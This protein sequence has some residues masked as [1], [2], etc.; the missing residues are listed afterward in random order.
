MGNTGDEKRM[1]ASVELLK[2]ML[3]EETASKILEQTG[4]L[5]SNPN[6]QITEQSGGARLNQAVECIKNAGLIIETPV[7]LWDLS[8]KEEFE[9]NIILFLQN[10]ITEQELRKRLSWM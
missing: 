5:P 10:K 1:E 6:I 9:E 2:Y 4:Q 7:N 8:K 3:S